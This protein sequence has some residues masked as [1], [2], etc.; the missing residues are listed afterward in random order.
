VERH[1]GLLAELLDAVLPADRVAAGMPKS[2]FAQR[3]GLAAKPVYV[4]LRRLAGGSLLPGTP[5]ELGLRLG[6]LP[7]CPVA[8]ER[9]IIVENEVTY[10]ALP[11][12]PGV[13]AV[14]GGGYG[15]HRLGSVPWLR[16]LP[17]RYW[18]DLDTHGF[19]I[20]HQLRKVFPGAASILMDR[21]TLE[22]HRDHWGSEPTQAKAS[23]SGLTGPE[24]ELYQ[25]L[26]ANT[27]GPGVRLEQERIRF[28]A[29]TEALAADPAAF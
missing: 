4:R 3:Y 18:G 10:L 17:L 25:D 7:V 28:S 15:V 8:A 22:S 19:A 27:Y 26:L 2:R 9:L 6:D 13:V 23:L 1:R 14:L 11:P 16:E 21:E 24:Q 20:L 12:V 5:A 29:V